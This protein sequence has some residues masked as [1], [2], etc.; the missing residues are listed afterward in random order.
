MPAVLIATQMGRGFKWRPKFT[1]FDG[2]GPPD[3][4]LVIELDG[5]PRDLPGLK[6]STLDIAIL[7]AETTLVRQSWIPTTGEYR[8]EVRPTAS[9]AQIIVR[10]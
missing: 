3:R 7:A 8:C 1:G 10:F 2:D 4:T 6:G 5:H 9:G